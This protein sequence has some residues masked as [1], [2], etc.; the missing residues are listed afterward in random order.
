MRSL[1]LQ[2]YVSRTVAGEKYY[3]W[4]LNPNSKLIEDAGWQEGD[5]IDAEVKNGRVILTRKRA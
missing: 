4:V 2:R 5:E 1:R 3:K